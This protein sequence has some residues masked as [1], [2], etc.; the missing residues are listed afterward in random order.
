MI[1]VTTQINAVSRTVGTRTWQ[2]GEVR[3][4]TVSQS[5]PTDAADLW[6]ACTNLERIPRWFLPITGDLLLGGSYQLQGNA[7]GTIL[8]CDPPRSFTA[9]WECN[10]QVS[11]IE[12][13]IVDEGPESARLELDH[14]APSDDDFWEQFGPSAVGMGWDGALVGLAIHTTTGQPIDPSFGPQWTV[15]DEGR[16]FTRETGA[17]W[18]AAHIAS[19]ENPEQARAAAA[20]CIAAYLGEEAN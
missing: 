11:W 1:D 8:D 6:D 16:R 18:C 5:Y 19:G 13:R 10:G 9:T 12:L 20:R 2:A 15:S 17:A 3:V 14:I 4:V 7:G